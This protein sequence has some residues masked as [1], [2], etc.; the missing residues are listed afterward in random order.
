MESGETG[1]EKRRLLDNGFSRRLS[2][3]ESP[4]LCFVPL[5]RYVLPCRDTSFPLPFGDGTMEEMSNRSVSF[6]PFG[7]VVYAKT[8]RRCGAWPPVRF[9]PCLFSPSLFPSLRHLSEKKIGPT[10]NI[11][12]FSFLSRSLIGMILEMFFCFSPI[13]IFLED[14]Y[15]FRVSLLSEHSLRISYFLPLTEH[16]LRISTSNYTLCVGFPGV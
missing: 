9:P 1:V 5:V 14:F 11:F 15:L 10:G 4:P 13:R 16:S 3:P 7:A 2:E 12:L 6:P 8:R